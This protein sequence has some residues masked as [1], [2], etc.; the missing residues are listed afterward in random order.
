[1]FRNYLKIAWRN[2]RKQPMISFINLFGL[3]VGLTCVAFISLWVMDEHSYDAFHQNY[4]R[5]VRLVTTEKTETGINESARTGAPMAKAL[6]EDYSEIENTVRLDKRGEIVQYKNKQVL[7]PNIILTDPSFFTIFSYP[8]I[9]GDAATALQEPYSVVLTEST[10]K[11][12]F[13]HADPMGQSLLIYMYDSTGRGANYKVTGITPDPPTNAHFTFSILGSFKTVETAKPGIRTIEGWSNHN[14]YTYL[15]LREG[16]DANRLSAKIAQFYAKHI[17]D[18][19]KSWR[20]VYSFKLQPLSDIHLRSHLDHELMANG[21]VG[22]VYIFSTIGLFILLLAAVNYTNLTTAR[23]L[24]RAKEIGVKK[25]LGAVRKQLILQHLSE[26]ILIALVAFGVSLLMSILGQSIFRQLTGKQI[27]LFSSPAL[28]LFLLGVTFFLGIVSGLYP[29]FVLSSYKPVVVLRGSL[30]ADVRGVALRQLLVV[31][32]FVITI[33]LLIGVVVIYTQMTYIKHKN[34]GYDKEALLFI[35]LNG[36][37]DVVAGYNAFRNDV[38]TSSL[39]NGVTASNSLIVNGLDAGTSE[40]VNRQGKPYKVT[41]SRLQADANYLSVHGIRLVAGRNFTPRDTAQTVRQVIVNEE[42]VRKL[43][44]KSA[45]SALGKPFAIDGKSGTVIGVI[46]DFHFN[47][48]QHTIEPLAIYP[49]DNYFSRITIKI[50][51]TNVSQ[52]IGFIEQV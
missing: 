5:I 21:D 47:S 16:V 39:V 41:T 44:W 15:L 8:L 51:P 43:N 18:L 27:S 35:R 30:K 9:R 48:L 10:A 3:A 31:S 52:G 6:L 12:Y 37:S 29:A 34:L 46:G 2:F 49:H 50:N 23:S 28:L 14:Y 45:E 13:A 11:K 20:S 17:G 40:T 25:V 19:L 22:Q 26:S 32:Q 33:A 38:L 4:T 7:E 24:G 42:V 36:N 1:M